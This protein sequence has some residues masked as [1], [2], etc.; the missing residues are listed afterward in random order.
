MKR[1]K[2][3]E[4]PIVIYIAR[5]GFGNEGLDGILNVSPEILHMQEVFR[6]LGIEI[7]GF[8]RCRESL[9]YALTMTEGRERVIIAHKTSFLKK[10][11]GYG[12][13]E[14]ITEDLIKSMNPTTRFILLD[15]YEELEREFLDAT[16]N[17]QYFARVIPDSDSMSPKGLKNYIC[18]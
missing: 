11:E 17:C 9:D 16:K 7:F 1:T 12:L 13:R 6:E 5:N 15:G 4:K 10:R 14:N 2:R 18:G 8:P 3:K